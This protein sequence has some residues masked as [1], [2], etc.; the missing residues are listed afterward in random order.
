L[1]TQ[2]RSLNAKHN[3]NIE[4]ISTTDPAVYPF[5]ETLLSD[6]PPITPADILADPLWNSAA[7][8]VPNNQVRY[9]INMARTISHAKRIGKPVL[10]WRN[11]L[12]GQ[13]AES[14]VALET[15]TLYSTHHALTSCYVAGLTCYMK[16][17]ISTQKGLVNGAQCVTDSITLSV[18]EDQER[19]QKRM[20]PLEDCLRA[21][22]PGEM[23]QL[24][25]PPL[26]INVV[27]QPESASKCSE[28]K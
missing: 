11:P 22:K 10:F 14:L 6:Y 4:K 7:I 13:N 28:P 12:V 8:V 17:N 3:A 25:L 27:M 5:T 9:D 23:V 18:E 24:A 21:A 19:I 2:Q 15:E 26:S 16:D 1:D 20:P